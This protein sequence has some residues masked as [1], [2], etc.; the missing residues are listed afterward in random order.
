[1]G[2]V[3]VV[4][5]RSDDGNGRLDSSRGEVGGESAR[6]RGVRRAVGGVELGARRVVLGELRDAL[7]DDR[8]GAGAGGGEPIDVATRGL[9]PAG[10]PSLKKRPSPARPSGTRSTAWWT[11][12]LPASIGC[13]PKG[14]A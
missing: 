9:D 3:G 6:I 1:V 11:S 7:V 4:D 2:E 14:S 12:A 10:R 5:R 8:L 13:S